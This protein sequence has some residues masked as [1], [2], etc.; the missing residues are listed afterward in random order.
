[1]MNYYVLCI[2]KLE[3]IY[4]DAVFFLNSCLTLFSPHTFNLA[5]SLM[6]EMILFLRIYFPF[7]SLFH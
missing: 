5:F 7:C 2:L 6:Q 1:M 3:P 4:C